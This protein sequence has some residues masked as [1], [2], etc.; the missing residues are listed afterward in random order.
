[1]SHRY[2]GWILAGVMLLAGSPQLFGQATPAPR[3]ADG[4]PDLTG[5]WGVSANLDHFT[6][7][8]PS[9]TPWGEARWKAAR[10]GT[11]TP[12]DQGREDIDP[13]LHPYCMTPGFP[14]IYLRPSPVEIAQTRDRVLM[15]FEVDTVW[16]VIYMD[17]REHTEGAPPT[18]MGHAVGRWDGDTLA[19]DT[20]GLNPL[21]WLDSIGTPHSDVLRVE[22]RI[23]RVAQD[24]MEMDLLFDDPKAYT[25]PWRGKRSWVLKPDWALME[26]GVCITDATDLYEEEIIRGKLG[27]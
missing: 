25:R 15:L 17:G 13:M 19:V 26:Y 18:F 8:V 1:M 24:K 7:E 11:R 3:R 10:E 21:T 14:R 12:L 2:V 23:R 5:V 22:E 16:R 9:F 20:V 6:T 4:T 27:E